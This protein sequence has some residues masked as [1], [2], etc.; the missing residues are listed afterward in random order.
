MDEDAPKLQVRLV[1]YWDQKVCPCC[2]HPMHRM[3]ELVTEQL[4]IEVKATVS[5][6]CAS[7]ICVP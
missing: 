4:H 6:E 5:A 2:S 7:Q 3:G 1:G